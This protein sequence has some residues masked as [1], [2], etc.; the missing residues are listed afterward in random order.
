M[1]EIDKSNQTLSNSSHL[2]VEIREVL[3]AARRTAY[4]AVNFAMVTA[5]WNVGRLI[6]EDEQ[7]GN[8]RAEYGKAI[9]ADLAK[10]L[11]DE[12]GKGFDERELRRIRQFYLVFPKWDALR[13]ELTWTHYRLL[14]RV[15]NEQARLWYMNEAAEQTWS[16]R[17]LD[18][19]IS[20]LYYERLLNSTDTLSVRKE[21]ENNLAQLAPQEFIHDPYVLEFLNLKN[22]PALHETDIEKSLINNL[23]S[24]LLELGKGFCFV[25]RQ[26]LMRYDNED[27]YVDLVFYHSILKCHVLIDLKLG[28]LTHQDVGQMDSYIRMFDDLYKHTDDNPTLGLILCSDKNEAVVKY[29]VLAE[30]R[31]IFA[32]KYLLEL[33]TPEVLQQEIM[34]E[35][36]QLEIE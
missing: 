7:Q 5:Y 17:Q 27:F 2:F 23:Q 30:H 34:R 29:S 14:I 8:T 28:K 22:Y 25:A 11:T 3:V 10:R 31:Q 15:Q 6:V 1:S 24:F 35:R 9:L 20:V 32:S 13:P 33:P 21:A 16:S 36:K 4:K 18:R 19:Q 26:K 12:F